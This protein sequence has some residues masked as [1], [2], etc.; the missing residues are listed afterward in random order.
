MPTNKP[1][2]KPRANG[3]TPTALPALSEIESVAA[4]SLPAPKLGRSLD[5]NEAKLAAAIVAATKGGNVA[6]GPAIGK[7]RSETN[8]ATATQ[9][10]A[11][12]KRLVGASFKLAGTPVAD[13]P[14]V[15]ARIVPKGD[16]FAWAISIGAPKPPKAAAPAEAPAEAA[17]TA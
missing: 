2:N 15:S 13:M 14:T 12:I 1:D 5:E 10:A 6:V 3:T 16:A 7:D 9:A 11:R 8:R 4:S 17:P